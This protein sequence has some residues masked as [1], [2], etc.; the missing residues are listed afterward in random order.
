MEP[1]RP[2]LAVRLATLVHVSDLH[3][4]DVDP[5]S[6]SK[7]AV[8]VALGSVGG[9]VFN[10][11]LGHSHNSLVRLEHPSHKTRRVGHAVPWS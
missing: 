7:D 9:P 1:I 3:F 2:R 10:G 5:K 11:L 8:P 6:L 4:G